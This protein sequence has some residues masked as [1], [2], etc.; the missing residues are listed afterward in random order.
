MSLL[1][2]TLN[3]NSLLE[4]FN[5]QSKKEWNTWL[6][7]HTI[8]KKLGKQGLVGLLSLKDNDCNHYIFKISQ[9]INYL[10]K[11]EY[12]IMKGLN[13]ISDYCIHFCRSYGII[14]CNLDSNIKNVDN[15]F[16][17]KENFIEK[18][19]LLCENITN[20]FKLYNY[21]RSIDKI[22]ENILYS[23]VKQV[24]MG[25]L[26][27]QKIKK[28]THYDLH[29]YNIMMKKCDK[30]TVFLYV[31]DENNQFC[32][33]TFGHYPVIIDF[34]FSYISDMEDSPLWT[35]LAHTNVGFT[36]DRFDWVADPKLFLVTISSEI[37]KKRNTKKSKKL[38]RITRNI[39]GCL[40]I[41]WECGW[42]DIDDSGASDY[43][44]NIIED[45]NQIS[46]LFKE[47][48]HY[49]IDL[50]HSLI[51]L[52]LQD[53]DYSNIH[54]S[55]ISFLEEWVKIE[56]EISSP[57]YNLYILKKI[58]DSARYVRAAYIEPETRKN[59]VVTFKN[60]IHNDINKV[61][62]FCR[63][64]KI[65][66]EKMLCS[67]FIFATN[68]EGVLNE[69][70]TIRMKEKQKEYNKLPL[71]SIEQI[72]NVI[73][74]NIPSKFKFNKQTKIVIFNLIQK[75]SEILVLNNKDIINI[76]ET[77]TLSRGKVLYNIYQNKN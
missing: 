4:I 24:L 64:K 12:T 66:Y 51:I 32:V 73:E 45:Y 27:A 62:K 28:F 2:S 10:V 70:M 77:D 11:H 7:F 23:S 20:S 39:F 18:D 5:Y 13:E 43:V 8:F 65:N 25:I 44:T 29:S 16:D 38:R 74:T 40:N 57:F 21:I 49:C 75:N 6:K 53:Q 69:I 42:D 59:S 17:C 76:N 37:K 47:Y 55:Y 72:F 50:F 9:Y 41:D 46:G 3:Y 22:D 54:I 19:V 60:M 52:P 36:S 33:P 67:M 61:I 71:T 34:G 14:N 35:S 68:I 30:N 1:K 63:P 56:N 15:P 31:I 48:N 26:T 58:I